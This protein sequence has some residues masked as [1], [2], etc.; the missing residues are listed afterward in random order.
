MLHRDNVLSASFSCSL[1]IWSGAP[2]FSCTMVQEKGA[3]IA[4]LSTLL[5]GWIQ[6]YERAFPAVP[7]LFTGKAQSHGPKALDST[8]QRW[9]KI[10][11]VKGF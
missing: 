4:L 5:V 6:Y 10:T 3:F 7:L 9:N 2:G 11:Y 8:C 1:Y